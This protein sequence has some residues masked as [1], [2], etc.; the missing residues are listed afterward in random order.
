[1]KNNREI[2][3]VTFGMSVGRRILSILE[4]LIFAMTTMYLVALLS[5]TAV[6]FVDGISTE[7]DSFAQGWFYRM[8]SFPIPLASIVG[9]CALFVAIRDKECSI[10]LY[11]FYK[12]TPK[13][14]EKYKEQKSKKVQKE[15]EG[16]MTSI[17]RHEEDILTHQEEIKKLEITLQKL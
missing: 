3:S 6:E 13:E 1:M 16:I 8:Q 14:I 15:I 17:K 9:A 4:A 11:R 10:F 2:Q 5:A 12:P 7:Y